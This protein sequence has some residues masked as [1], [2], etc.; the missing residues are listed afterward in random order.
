MVAN[1]YCMK[2]FEIFSVDYP[3][4]SVIIVALPTDERD[5][6]ISRGFVNEVLVLAIKYI[7]QVSLL[8]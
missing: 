5:A 2:R 3:L 8:F 4:C 1:R 7:H 6:I